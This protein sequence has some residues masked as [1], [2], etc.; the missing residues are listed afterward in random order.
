MGIIKNE[1]GHLDHETLNSSV[2]HNWFN[3][4]SRFI[5]WNLNADGDGLILVWLPNKL[6]IFDI[7]CCGSTAVVVAENDILVL[8]PTRK[9]SDIG[10]PKF[11]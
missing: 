4:L 2:W 3:E 9:I 7:R 5:E 8:V 6:Y 11:L 10:L 1:C